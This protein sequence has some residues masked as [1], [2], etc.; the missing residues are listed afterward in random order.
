[1]HKLRSVIIAVVL[2][3][4]VMGTSFAQKSY[5]VKGGMLVSY[6]QET[7]KMLKGEK[8]D[9]SK[10]SWCLGFVQASVMSHQLFSALMTLKTPGHENLSEKEFVQKV[11]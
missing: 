9:V 8:Y 6:C 4:L 7:L 10:S 1:M 2:S 3:F 5:Y 11:V